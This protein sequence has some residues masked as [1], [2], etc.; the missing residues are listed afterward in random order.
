MQYH[1]MSKAEVKAALKARTAEKGFR[2]GMPLGAK[3]SA[4]E[5]V[6]RWKDGEVCVRVK[7][8]WVNCLCVVPRHVH[9]AREAN[10]L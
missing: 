1:G 3:I 8:R 6:R 9:M 2:G 5:A 10:S 4:E 7:K